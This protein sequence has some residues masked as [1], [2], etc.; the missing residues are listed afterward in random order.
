MQR[1]GRRLVAVVVEADAGDH[2]LDGVA[3]ELR[4]AVAKRVHHDAQVGGVRGGQ[5][6]KGRKGALETRVLLNAKV[7]EGVLVDVR[8][9]CGG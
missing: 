4:D 8:Q 2:R 1:D 6:T 5:A 9:L 7:V 3:F